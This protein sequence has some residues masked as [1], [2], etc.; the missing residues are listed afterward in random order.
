M[1]P[2]NRPALSPDPFELLPASALGAQLGISADAVKA[3]EREGALFSNL[4]EGFDSGRAYA[5]F[6]AWP[7]IAGCP[8]SSV[9]EVL[10]HPD[11]SIAYGFF[12]SGSRELEELSPVEVL[13]GRLLRHRGVTESAQLLLDAQAEVRLSV[14]FGAANAFL[15][16]RDC[17]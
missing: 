2:S 10:G 6:Q 17:W 15:A 14:V 1:T 7:G 11:G 16:D 12:S 4:P 5:A 8:L 13:S 9:L 3:L